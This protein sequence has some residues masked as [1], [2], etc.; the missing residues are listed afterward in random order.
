MIEFGKYQLR[1]EN[2]AQQRTS[3]QQH[4]FEN[5]VVM[6]PVKLDEHKA[7]GNIKTNAE[8]VQP[9]AILKPAPIMSD[10][11][12]GIQ[13]I[14]RLHMLTGP[15]SGHEILLSKALT[16]FGEPSVQVVVITKRPHGYFLSH[17]EGEKRPLVNGKKLGTQ[18]H[19]L[20]DRDV[21][22]LVGMTMEFYTA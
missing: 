11:I 4:G 9:Q 7:Q 2:T 3:V 12:S 19:E 20:F 21:I 14:G 1:Y 18:A 22:D 17:V 6:R 10:P 8:Q 5:T 13:K 15:S 16:T